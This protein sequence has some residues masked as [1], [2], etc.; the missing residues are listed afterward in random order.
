MKKKDF[1]SIGNVLNKATPTDKPA[2]LSEMMGVEKKQ[3]E[4]VDQFKKDKPDKLIRECISVYKSDKDIIDDLIMKCAAT[5]QKATKA[6]IYRASLK[7][8]ASLSPTA[9]ANKVNDIRK[10]KKTHN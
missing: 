8:F 6:D 10:L 9:I 3:E 2:S 4:D 5:G 7:H 1:S